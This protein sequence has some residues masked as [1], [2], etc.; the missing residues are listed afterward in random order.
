MAAFFDL[1][2]FSYA[3]RGL[4]RS[5]GTPENSLGAFAAAAAAGLGIEFD[6]RPSADGE[7]MIFHD[8]LLERMSTA[9]GRFEALDAE[10]L[11]RTRLR[12]DT[13]YIPSFDALLEQWPDDLPL[14]TEMKIDGATDPVAFARRVGLRLLRWDGPAAAM[15][16]SEAAVRAL[17]DGIMRGQ[18]IYPAARSDADAFTGVYQRAVDDG[19]DYLAVHH[20]DLDRLG[21]CRLPVVT[22]TVR[23]PDELG[24]ARR[25]GAAIIFEHLPVADVLEPGA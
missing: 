14:L 10:T 18:L 20:S 1:H 21:R 25:T 19:I 12:P 11:A 4:W 23:T 17:P 6:V 13:D 24:Q 2:G 8:P 7:I 9:E 22:W 15:S 3:H 5:D 16:F